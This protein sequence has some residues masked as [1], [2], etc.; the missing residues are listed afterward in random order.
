MPKPE[1]RGAT[2][3]LVEDD[4]AIRNVIVA[5]LADE[6]H[7]VLTAPDGAVAL[8]LIKEWGQRP[9]DVILLDLRLP[10]MDGTEFACRYGRTPGPHAPIVVV[11]AA[12]D[13]IWT[14]SQLGAAG[15]LTKPFD[16]DDLLEHVDRYGRGGVA[17]VA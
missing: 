11:T 17:G 4:E 1:G 5:A 8:A 6:G 7:T 9:L 16:L 3:L 10:V 15:M 2:V 14:A 13:G 12:A